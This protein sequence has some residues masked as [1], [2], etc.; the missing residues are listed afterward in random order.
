[1]VAGA[2][3]AGALDDAAAVYPAAQSAICLVSM[4]TGGPAAPRV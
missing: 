3:G 1:M 4:V 2:F